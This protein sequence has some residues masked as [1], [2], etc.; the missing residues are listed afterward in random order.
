[1]P[2]NSIAWLRLIG[3]AEGISLLVLM[4]IAMPLKYLA[5]SP[6][7]VTIVGWIHGVLFVVFMIAVLIVYKQRKWRFKKIII[8]FIAA[9]LP[10]GTFVFDRQLR[11][12]EE[13]MKITN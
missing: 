11:A 7:M 10:F 4:G 5:E 8:A 9:L 3:F 12:E 1:M 6:G 13:Q 2:E